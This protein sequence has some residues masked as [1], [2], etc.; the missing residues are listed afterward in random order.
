MTTQRVQN[1]IGK[2]WSAAADGAL[3]ERYDPGDRRRL[4]AVAPDST[5]TDAAA[6][7]A[8]AEAA[9]RDWWN[10]GMARRIEVIER[11]LGV[12][13]VQAEEIAVATV[14]ESGKT[15][16][17][18]RGEVVRAIDTVREQV[19]LASAVASAVV[20]VEGSVTAL[21]ERLPVGI[22]VVV[23]PWNFPFSALLRK[24]VPALVMGNAVVA[25]PS[26]L[27]PVSADRI[28]RAFLAAGLPAGVLNVIHGRGAVVGAALVSDERVGAISFTG[29]TGVG[30][31]IAEQVGRS[32]LKVQLEMGGKNPLVV[33]ADAD[34]EQA[35]ADAVTGAFTAA[36][37]WCVATSRI[38]LEEPIAEEFTKRL[39]ARVGDIQ[40]GHGLDPAAQMGALVSPEHY[41]KVRGFLE[42]AQREAVVLSGGMPLADE[43]RRHGLFVAPTVLA[44]IPADSELLT[45]EIFGPV[46]ALLRAESATSAIAL[47]AGSRYGLSAS[48]Y[49]SDPVAVRCFLDTV[50]TGK[51]NINRPPH[52][53][54]PRLASSGRR[55]SGRGESE[56]AASGLAF[57]T[58]ERAVFLGGLDPV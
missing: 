46:V 51:A 4:V 5:A 35:V 17:E 22:A 32:D 8:A 33:L 10:A 52:F 54:D 40:V 48:L 13:Q 21:A 25:K 31:A 15:L 2:E 57:Y 7:L 30:L 44:G 19:A 39:L 12:L 1:L 14:L 38:I 56:G 37:Q 47:A 29:S 6:A 3:R 34:L 49:T 43:A 27:S 18:C 20:F 45:Q 9:W 28:A 55:D 58:H 42:L 24:V 16:A 41:A 23:T 50:V 11:A 36:G 26:E 53:G